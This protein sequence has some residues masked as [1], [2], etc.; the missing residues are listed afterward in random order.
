[1]VEAL[2][3]N[4]EASDDE[5]QTQTRLELLQKEFNSTTETHLAQISELNLQN[6]QL[7]QKLSDTEH[8]NR[9][10]NT[11]LMHKLNEAKM[12]TDDLSHVKTTLSDKLKL[13]EST[14]ARVSEEAEA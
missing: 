2:N 14:K 4:N 5:G 1:M 8:Q 9:L 6:E 10:A 11:E 13:L 7:Q 3:K 12:T